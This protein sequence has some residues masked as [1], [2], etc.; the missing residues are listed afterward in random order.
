MKVE[1]DRGTLRINENMEIPEIKN[2]N[3]KKYLFKPVSELKFNHLRGS[4][5]LYNT[6]DSIIIF[7]FEYTYSKKDELNVIFRNVGFGNPDET[8]RLYTGEEL[9]IK[10]E[11]KSHLYPQ[12]FDGTGLVRMESRNNLEYKYPSGTL[13]IKKSIISV[14]YTS[15]ADILLGILFIS[16][17]IKLNKTNINVKELNEIR[18]RN[19]L[20]VNTHFERKRDNLDW[21]QWVGNRNKELSMT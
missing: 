1:F 3:D 19:R 12:I 20:M 14:Y 2:E 17:V 21:T 10:A 7:E 11:G 18:V 9:G 16:E 8:K 5:E 6:A 13:E 4:I 15:F